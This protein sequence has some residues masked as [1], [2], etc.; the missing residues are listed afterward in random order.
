[1]SVYRRISIANLV[2]QLLF[3]INMS[4]LFGNWLYLQFDDQIKNDFLNILIGIGTCTQASIAFITFILISSCTLNTIFIAETIQLILVA[5]NFI[6]FGLTYFNETVEKWTSNE[7]RYFANYYGH[8]SAFCLA[9]IILTLVAL[10]FRNGPEG[11]FT[12]CRCCHKC[13]KIKKT[14]RKRQICPVNL[15]IDNIIVKKDP[16]QEYP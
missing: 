1:M 5:L 12:L 14:I 10:A 7:G 13:Q 2:F 16:V 11:E 9:G 6:I 8:M 3:M 15:T 4:W